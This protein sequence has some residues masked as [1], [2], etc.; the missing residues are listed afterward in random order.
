MEMQH[1]LQA[2]CE[3]PGVGGQEQSV[4]HIAHKILCEYAPSAEIDSFHNVMG[5]VKMP[6][7]NKPMVLLDAHIDQIGFII[8]HI[9]ANGF[10]RVGACGGVDRRVLEGQEVIL[11]GKRSIVGVVA[12]MPPHLTDGKQEKVPEVESILI[13][14]G[15]SKQQLT[16]M[17]SV[18]D[19][20]LLRPSFHTLLGT[21]VASGGLDDRCGVAVILKV[22]DLLRDKQTTCGISVLFSAQEEVGQRGAQIASYKM[23]PDIAI[24]VDVSFAKTPDVS[25]WDCKEMGEGGMVGISPTLDREISHDLIAL[26]KQN[27]IPYQTEVMK[28]VTGTNADVIGTVRGGVRTGLVS[29]P[30]KYMHTPVEVIDIQDCENVAKLLAA[31]LLSL[32]A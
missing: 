11:Y 25:E 30:L 15:L 4:S 22:L 1:T 28:G 23:K 3:A 26:A 20:A 31:Y 14:T 6:E 9:D 19:C 13:D 18:G 21:R 2:L 17:I 12:T 16:S 5:V 8:T 32:D 27:N 29:I 10:V 24:A 7:Q